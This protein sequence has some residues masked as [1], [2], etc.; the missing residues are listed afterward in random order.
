MV[1]R[2]FYVL[3][4]TARKLVYCSFFIWAI[5]DMLNSLWKWWELRYVFFVTKHSSVSLVFVV[6]LI[7]LDFMLLIFTY[8]NVSSTISCMFCSFNASFFRYDLVHILA[9]IGYVFLW[10]KHVDIAGVF[11]SLS[12]CKN[13]QKSSLML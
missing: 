3:L 4:L 5:H 1:Y 13:R 11:L 12:F 10:I 6:D 2:L 7:L 9:W 8:K